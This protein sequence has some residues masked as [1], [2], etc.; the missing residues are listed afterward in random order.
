MHAARWSP[1]HATRRGPRRVRARVPQDP[2]A[3]S[4]V[5]DDLVVGLLAPRDEQLDPGLVRQDLARRRKIAAEDAPQHGIEEEHG[6]RAE[7][8]VGPARFEEVDRGTCQATELDLPCDLVD[9]LIA[10]LLGRL[11]GVHDGPPIVSTD[12][13][14][15]RLNAS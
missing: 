1:V 15:A 11:E 8:P 7:R 10:L 6:V 13:W 4:G 2:R 3:S 14:S 9:E 12:G 5:P